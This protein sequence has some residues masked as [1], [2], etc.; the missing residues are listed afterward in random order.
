MT[1]HVNNSKHVNNKYESSLTNATSF[2][3]LLYCM[4]AI[5]IKK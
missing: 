4:F 1:K 2:S 3:F 5:E